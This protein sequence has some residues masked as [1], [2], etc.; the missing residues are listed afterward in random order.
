[1]PKRCKGR[2]P[3]TIALILAWADDHKARTGDYPTTGS[4]AVLG[5][6]G[7]TWRNLHQALRAGCR[8]LPGGDTLAALLVRERGARKFYHLPDLTEEQIVG[9]AKAHKQ[10][11]G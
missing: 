4:G 1:M 9:W 6:P 2:P 11:T 10:R 8:S 5:A 7:E 3:L